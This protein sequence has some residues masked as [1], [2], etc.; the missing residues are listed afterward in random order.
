MNRKWQHTKSNIMS[1][2]LLC[3]LLSAVLLHSL[4]AEL[5][6]AAN[7]MANTKTEN[8]G[9]NRKFSTEDVEASIKRAMTFLAGKEGSG[10]PQYSDYVVFC[11]LSISRSYPE[12]E[13]IVEPYKMWIAKHDLFSAKLPYQSICH[14]MAL[15][16]SGN[17]EQALEIFSQ[18][19]P[20]ANEGAW[21]IPYHIGWY[22]YGCLVAGDTELGEKTFDHLMEMV[23]NRP[24]KFQYFTAYCVWKAYEKSHDER[25]R[26]AFLT[27]ANNLRRFQGEYVQMAETD[28]HMGMVLAVFCRAFDLTHDEEYRA[29][30]RDLA[31]KLLSTQAANGSWN[32]KTAYTI[33]PAEGLFL[34]L[35]LCP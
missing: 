3:A 28:G 22:L 33:M 29:M 5:A 8:A 12:Y 6:A 35:T 25:Y 17:R 23:E 11:G 31:G 15:D 14:V 9:A 2:S 1:R 32:D 10:G 13:G 19:K 18:L 21:L 20:L 16:M 26:K 7:T 27:I 34:Y 4:A 24:E 30:A